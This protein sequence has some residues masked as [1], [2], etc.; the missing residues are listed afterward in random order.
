MSQRHLIPMPCGLYGK[1][2]SKRDFVAIATPRGF[3]EA[4]E[5]WL[6]GS[7][8]SSRMQLAADWQAAFLQAPVWRFWLGAS[9]FGMS[10]AG[11]FVASVDGVGRF[12]PLTLIGFVEDGPSIPPPELDPLDGWFAEAEEILLSAR[13][14]EVTFDTVA[15]AVAAAPEPRAVS[16][17]APRLNRLAK[18]VVSGRAE[19]SIQT[20]F[21][22]IRIAEYGAVYAGSTF[23]WTMGKDGR[24]AHAIAARGLPDPGLF[25][26]MLSGRFDAAPQ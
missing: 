5:P 9:I 11:C 22:E 21:G 15:A 16:E 20:F 19:G 18:G 4:W 8:T 7:V 12:F 26:G 23:W 17:S 25:A 1:L 13:T 10:T 6:Q 24:V 2:P 14:R 3:L